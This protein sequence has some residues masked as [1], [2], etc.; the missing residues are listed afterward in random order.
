MLTFFR[1]IRKAL[2]DSGSARKYL[3]YAIGEIALVM[4]GILLALQVNNWNEWRKD[5][6][7]ERA[8]LIQLHEEFINNKAELARTVD[9][10]RMILQNLTSLMALFPSNTNKVDEKTLK[11]CQSFLMPAAQAY[12]F[13]PSNAIINALINQNSFDLITDTALREDVLKWRAVLDD[14]LDDER[15]NTQHSAEQI[16]PYLAAK[17]IDSDMGL[18][19]DRLDISFLGTLEF[20]GLIREKRLR[21]N[22]IYGLTNDAFYRH[23]EKLHNS[24]ENI[25]RLTEPD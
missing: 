19:D 16:R 13:N 12:T 24:I 20:E 7:T 1:K 23:L 2:L 17:G 6:I 21:L 25:I 14:Y 10:N 18:F 5:R 8:L 11:D 4:I 9:S 22:R 15:R 3:L